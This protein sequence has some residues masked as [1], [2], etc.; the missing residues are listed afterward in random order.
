MLGGGMGLVY[1]AAYIFCTLRDLAG[2][3]HES[4]TGAEGVVLVLVGLVLVGL[5]FS[6]GIYPVVTSVRSG[7][8]AN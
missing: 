6:A 7:W 8:Q 1:E 3:H 5:V 2:G 4:R